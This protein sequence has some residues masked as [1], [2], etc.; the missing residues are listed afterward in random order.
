MIDTYTKEKRYLDYGDLQ[1]SIS[2]AAETLNLALD[3]LDTEINF[4]KKRFER[5]GT[6]P[7]TDRIE[8]LHEVFHLVLRHLWDI[9]DECQELANRT[10]H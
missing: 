8:K 3:E 7:H 2:M 9:R 4:I 5:N 6:E 10:P 1:C